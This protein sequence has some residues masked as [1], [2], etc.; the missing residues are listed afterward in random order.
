MCAGC[1]HW[2][3]LKWNLFRSVQSLKLRLCEKKSSLFF[4]SV[5]CCFIWY[6]FVKLDRNQVKKFWFLQQL[7]LL[8]QRHQMNRNLFLT[9]ERRTM[10]VCLY[11]DLK[12]SHQQFAAQNLFSSQSSDPSCVLDLLRELD[13]HTQFVVCNMLTCR[14]LRRP[15]FIKDQLSFRK[16]QLL[17]AGT[18]CSSGLLCYVAFTSTIESKFSFM[19]TL[20][21]GLETVFCH[22]LYLLC[23]LLFFS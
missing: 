1:S 8:T 21:K 16:P 20:I 19:W 13:L 15:L 23:I 10:K 11:G 9:G 17:A 5:F 7:A 6:L 14:E 22:L 18:T 2:L 4:F 12:L 3:A